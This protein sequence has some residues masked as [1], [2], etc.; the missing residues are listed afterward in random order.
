[1]NP[2]P[3]SLLVAFAAIL[4]LG[5]THKPEPPMKDKTLVA[6][7]KLANLTQRG[8]SVLTIEDG[9][10]HFDG[11]V[12]GEIYPG[13]WMAGSDLYTRTNQSQNQSPTET[14]ANTLIQLAITY[15]DREVTLYRNGEV[16]DHHTMNGEPQTFG[17]H[18]RVTIGLRHHRATDQA[19]FAGSID[20]ARIYSQAL[21]PNQI[22]GLRPNEPSMIKPW[23]W[24]TFNDKAAKDQTGRFKRVE[25]SNTKIDN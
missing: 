16:I 25:L 13:K 8:G 12:F 3:N 15:R 6:W 9:K 23:A 5:L 18:S 22:N 2:L 19:H 1:M 7:V 10:D 17:E 14:T 11:I 24:W 20:D 4:A 21:S